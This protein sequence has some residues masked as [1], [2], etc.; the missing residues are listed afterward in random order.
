MITHPDTYRI[1]V[2]DD[3]PDVY[4]ITRLSLRKM[5]YKGQRVKIIKA[6]SG[7]EAIAAMRARPDTALIL[8][9]VVME[10]TTAGLDAC[11]A[12]REELG[13]KLVR[14]IIRTGQ[15][16]IA[17]ERQVIDEYD[18]DGYLAKAELTEERL[19]VAARTA[20]KSFEDLLELERHRQALDFIHQSVIRLH[21]FEPLEET[22][23]RVLSTAATLV[24]CELAILNLE[25]FTDQS[26][27]EGY[28]LHLEAE[29]DSSE[30]EAVASEI[31]TEIAIN[32]ATAQ[33]AGS[34]GDGYLVP[35]FLHRELGHGWIYLQGGEPDTLARQTLPLLAAHA[36]NALYASV[37]QAILAASDVP[38]YDSLIV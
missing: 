32:P 8:L 5:R 2:V 25:T 18:I 14:I 11:R 12:I 26:N 15:P 9:D 1:L 34:F 30:A 3:E 37:A 31:R 27:P 33:T 4:A 24:P 20:I 21:S 19:Y 6:T 7:A 28:L 35:F 22:L 38:F 17:P 23:E 13:N 36:A 16:G 10:T 29:A